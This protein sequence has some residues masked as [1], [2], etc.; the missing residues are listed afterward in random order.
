MKRIVVVAALILAAACWPA[1]KY[2]RSDRELLMLDAGARTSAPGKFVKLSDGLVHYELGGPEGGRTVVLVH[3]FSVPYYLWDPTFRALTEAGFRVLRYDLFGRGF[4]DR[5]DVTYDGELYRRQLV[6]LLDAL[7]IRGKV[8]LMGSSMGGPIV[9]GFGCK[10]PERVRTVS[11]FGPGFSR[12]V[13]LPFKLRAPLVG[14]Y[15]MAVELAPV[16][17]HAQMADFPASGTI[18]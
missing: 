11:L 5:P 17:P 15:T 1:V 10:H 9:A 3:G 16:L 2:V 12:G 4:S 7:Q 18:S 13:Q 8:D 14:E 6:E